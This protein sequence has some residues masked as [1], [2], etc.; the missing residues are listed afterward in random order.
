MESRLPILPQDDSVLRQPTMTET[1]SQPV[2][3]LLA[4]DS[5]FMLRAVARLLRTTSQV[6]LIGAAVDFA[7][8]VRLAHEHKPHVVI[9]DLHM[10]LQ[11]KADVLRLKAESGGSR[12]LAITAANVKDEGSLALAN[13]IGADRLLDKM[14]LEEELIPA[15]LEL[16]SN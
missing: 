9:L 1:G 4:D 13:A 8:A 5:E 16:A 6:A 12:L 15:I 7:E 3:V 14:S 2:K 10:A 11:A